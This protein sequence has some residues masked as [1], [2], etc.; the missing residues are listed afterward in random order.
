MKVIYW[1]RNAKTG[2][3]LNMANTFEQALK[4]QDKIYKEQNIDTFIEKE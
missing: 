2:E 4:I 3:C 1:I